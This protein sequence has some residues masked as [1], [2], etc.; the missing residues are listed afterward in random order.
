MY[1][2]DTHVNRL[3]FVF[4]L[5]FFFKGVFTFIGSAGSSLL[6]VGFL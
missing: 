4:L 6:R 2:Q 1:V 5:F 3:L